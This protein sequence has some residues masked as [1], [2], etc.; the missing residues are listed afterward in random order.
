MSPVD[1]G[2]FL[3][4]WS[5][6]KQESLREQRGGTPSAEPRIAGTGPVEAPMPPT[7]GETTVATAAEPR[8]EITGPEQLSDLIG[9]D[10]DSLDY[11]SDYTRFMCKGIP[12]ELRTNALRK[13]WASDPV[14]AHLDG[15]DDCCGDFTDAARA[16]PALK[17]AY[18]I[19]RGFLTDA[20]VE[21]WANLGK[22]RIDAVAKA[23]KDGLPEGGAPGGHETVATSGA[24]E[25][26][27]I[28]AAGEAG[29]DAIETADGRSPA[30][31]ATAT[32]EAEPKFEPSRHGSREPG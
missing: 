19:G 14:F 20:E 2:N 31:P 22:P 27:E 4:R 21:E 13:L 6:R 17:T 15:L 3:A 16:D 11:N 28:A 25:H 7:E 23:R 5:R 32:A 9:I 30:S 10:L 8:A 29:G 18:R 24:G 1:D 26:Q 12:D